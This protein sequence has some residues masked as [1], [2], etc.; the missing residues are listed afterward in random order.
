MQQNGRK[1]KPSA[2]ESQT[3]Q[4][5]PIE[6][7]H[8]VHLLFALVVRSMGRVGWYNRTVRKPNI[9]LKQ[10]SR[11]KNKICRE[12]IHSFDFLHSSPLGDSFPRFI[13]LQ[14]G[15]ADA[16]GLCGLLLAESCVYSGCC[17]R[18]FGKFLHLHSWLTSVSV[19]YNTRYKRICQAK[20]ENIFAKY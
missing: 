1:N 11:Q 7:T 17:K 10:V 20:S 9:R 16:E 2:N 13:V 15:N 14:R 3:H 5:G 8:T 18:D 12:I 19:S 4:N 6:I